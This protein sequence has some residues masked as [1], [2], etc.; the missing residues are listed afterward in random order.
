[1]KGLAGLGAAVTVAA[2]AVYVTTQNGA[3]VSIDLLF[4]TASGVPAWSVLL[5][6]FAAGAIASGLALAWP[7]LRLR[8]KVRRQTRRV[9]R[10]EQEVH[11]L[12]T[13]P[14]S[15]EEPTTTGR[16]REG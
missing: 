10:L 15:P 5:G 7:L 12:R 4:T 3:P 11:G 16:A 8:F 6:S 9:A 1:M 14:L 2:Y 13:L